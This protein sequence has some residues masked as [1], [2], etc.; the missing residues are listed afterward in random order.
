ME[1]SVEN[2]SLPSTAAQRR[3]G[4]PAATFTGLIYVVAFIIGAI[5][6][7]FEMLGSRYLNPYFG[8]GI[9]T[10]AALISTVLAALTAGY[11]IGGFVAD[12]MPS[13]AL[14]GAAVGVASLYLLLLPGFAEGVLSFV[15][16]RVADVRLGSLYAALAIMLVPVTLL[17]VYSPFA[18]RLVLSTTG[19]S[20]TV[21]GAVYGV[22]TAGSIAG[23]LGTT[24]FL[25]PS[26]GTRAITLTL[27]VAGI[28]CAL[29]LMAAERLPSLPRQTK[30]LT[31]AIVCAALAFGGRAQ[32]ESLFDEGVRAQMLARRS[33][34][35]VH[36]ETEY[37]DLYISKRGPLLAL[38][39]R[40]KNELHFHSIVDLK[41]PDEMPVPYTQTFAAALLYP[42]KVRRI[43]MVGLGA[44]SIS[45]YLGRALPDVSIDVV[46]LDPGVIAAGRKYFGLLQTERV[47]FIESDGR[48]YLNRNKG[49]Y[50]LILL[51]AF[52]EQ[53]VPFHLLTREFYSLVKERLAPGGAVASNVDDDTRLYAS[54][55][56]TFGAVF[57]TVDVYRN[58]DPDESQSI[59]VA[60]SV[61]KPSEETLMGR[62]NTLQQQHHFR[63]PMA[64]RV[65]ERLTDAKT[66]GAEVLTDDF[67]PVDIYRMT[68]LRPQKGR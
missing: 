55:L 34:P 22:S 6:M 10:W 41:D 36:I 60:T 58:K 14:L 67:A 15:F 7:S 46:E 25:I 30:L 3:A 21:S 42:E 53:G 18:I 2:A 37:N 59:V 8:N 26:I 40:V 12:R 61:A 66:D 31:W 27:G 23:T 45:T 19:H 65:A 13:A 35:V 32:G 28:A 62:A 11:F 57:P 56:A 68:P 33:G 20:G 1:E 38:T 9:Y 63:Y 47:H 39:T 16:D 4:A 48:V 51:D 52:R 29:A 17:G 5:V 64:D 50:D 24:F 54:T 44:G 49:L 43:L